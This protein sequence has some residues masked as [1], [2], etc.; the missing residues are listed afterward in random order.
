MN[1]SNQC[2]GCMS[3]LPF[4]EIHRDANFPAEF[5]VECEGCG[6]GFKVKAEVLFIALDPDEEV[7]I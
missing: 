1:I 5:L 6:C 7:A 3:F 4:A 2:P